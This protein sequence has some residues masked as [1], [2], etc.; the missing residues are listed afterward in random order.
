M[1]AAS[2]GL[3]LA[4]LAVTVGAVEPKNLVVNGDF[5]RLNAKGQPV[6]WEMAGENTWVQTEA[7]NHYLTVS[8]RSD[9]FVPWASQ[10]IDLPANTRRISI[11]ARMKAEDFEPGD[12]SWQTIR[13]G[14]EFR[15][16][17]GERTGYLPPLNLNESTD[18]WVNLSG[19]GE[20]PEGTVRI[21]LQ[22]AQ[23]GKQ[24]VASFDDI[25]IAVSESVPPQPTEDAAQPKELAEQWRSVSAEAVSPTRGRLVVDGW[26]KFMPATPETQTEPDDGGW[27]YIRVPGHWASSRTVLREGRGPAWRQWQADGPR[28]V[29]AAWYQREVPIPADW[30][31]RAILLEIGRV[32]TDAVVYVNGKSCGQINWPWGRV[33]ITDAVTPGQPAKVSLF[34]AATL[35][36]KTLQRMMGDAPGQAFKEK[37]KLRTRGITEPVV[38]HSRPRGP[39]V[40]DVFVQP[41]V[42]KQ[43]IT[44]DLELTGV[45]EAGP[46]KLVAKMLDEQ[47]EAEQTFERTIEA[48]AKDVQRVSLTW[49]WEDARLWDEGQPN[50]Y[51]LRLHTQ[52]QGVDDVYATRFGFREFWIEGRNYYL[53]GRKFRARTAQTGIDRGQPI[54]EQIERSRSIGMNLLESW[55][56][57]L[58]SERGRDHRDAEWFAACDEAGMPI[59]GVMPHVGWKGSKANTDEEKADLERWT[60]RVRRRYGNHPSIVMWGSSGNA[61]GAE[62]DPR[63]VGNYEQSRTQRMR[64]V[65]RDADAQ[66]RLEW[67]EK[68][69][70]RIDPTRP[71]FFHNCGHVGDV[72]TLNHYLNMTPLQERMEWISQY[73]AD[74]DMPLWY[75][76]FGMP[77]HGSVMRGRHGWGNTMQTEPL[78]TE[79]AAIYQ[80]EQAYADEPDDYRQ[81]IAERHIEDQAYQT[82]HGNKD[83]M[84][85]RPFQL[86]AGQFTTETFRAWRTLGMTGGMIPWTDD[87]WF[88]DGSWTPTGQAM[89]DSNMPT[90]AWICGSEQAGVTD[91]THHFRSGDSV[92]KRIAILNDS[93]TSRRV[94]LSWSARSGD[95]EL[96]SGR[97]EM[98]IAPGQTR[99]ATIAFE[100]PDVKD[101]GKQSGELSIKGT[102]GDA[103]H[104]DSFAFTTFGTA[105]RV[106]LRV[107]AADSAGM[108]STMLQAAG[109]SVEPWDGQPTDRLVIVGRQHDQIESAKFW[110]QIRRH[111]E[112][113]GRC[114]VFVQRPE[115]WR[116]VFDFR[117]AAHQSR[118]VFTIDGDHPIATGLDLDD[119]RHWTG[120]ST[121]LEPHPTYESDEMSPYNVPYHGWRWGNRH[122]VSSGA[123]EK[124]HRAGWR[125][126]LQCEFD[127]AYSPLMELDFGKGRLT[128]CQLDLEDHYEQ[129][130]AAERMAVRVIRHAATADLRARV[131]TYFV[132][133]DEGKARL[134]ALDLRYQRTDRLP[135]IEETAL[136][137]VEDRSS[138]DDGELSRWVER[139][140]RL[141]VLAGDQ[142]GGLL[143]IQRKRVDDYGGIDSLTRSHPVLAGLGAS[144]LRYRVDHEAWL[145]DGGVDERFAD[146]QLGVRRIGSGIAVFAQLNPGRFDA[147]RQTY[148]RFTRWR[149]TRAL[150]QVLANLGAR[151]EQDDRV[152]APDRPDPERQPI[153]VALHG[154]WQVTVTQPMPAAPSPA[155]AHRDPGMSDTARQIVESSD[156]HVDWKTLTA[157]G[158]IEQIDGWAAVD[159]E[160][161]L[162]RTFEAPD[163]LAGK[164]CWLSLGVVDDFDSTFINGERVGQVDTRGWEVERMYRVPP[165]LLKPGRNT[166]VV[167]G[168]DHFGGGGL[169]GERDK[170]WIGEKP[171]EQTPRLSPLYHPDYRTDF[172]LGDDPYRYYNF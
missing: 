15:D 124:P 44:L 33:D 114:L 2:A 171:V 97:V 60:D 37:A 51:E 152:F 82:F 43:Q 164:A 168:W 99:F 58:W 18:D 79:Y 75:V 64:T 10:S 65:P 172:D 27:G 3:V 42:R 76:E 122:T 50:L 100:A 16:A 6:C 162:R 45:S 21:Q 31:G 143:G 103:E 55:P 1:S 165:G 78:V 113:G 77:V 166:I 81:E 5:E 35:H 126:I 101:G 72:Y 47:G 49:P 12:K 131:D 69:I 142:P 130:P 156:Q 20:V 154:D 70:K 110:G 71:V 98:E 67:M 115:V 102:V 54:P 41:S 28:S 167:R 29:S 153:Q 36:Q 106:D 169:T 140:N 25:V 107:A 9:S 136:L 158:Q 19:G 11:R 90:L 137:I 59:T 125:P 80:G 74:G 96:K 46:V 56:M 94:D 150:T 22:A 8:K 123:L 87:F 39:H 57:D 170:L 62:K 135:A 52:G 91:R 145:I 111:V 127:L 4:A 147:D 149:Q 159:G 61:M 92:A 66:E 157:P 30:D 148:F 138:L 116:K 160:Y 32:S 119:L 139:G 26:W 144:D 38:L 53:N 163:G 40:S 146:G 84:L 7:D 161:V 73:A 24:G 118:R 128:L 13:L 109:A 129:D 93:A 89:R 121:L 14:G 17:K 83:V 117:V 68:T 85:S 105:A 88:P 132:G 141:L 134:D 155:N 23:F 112:Q 120:N 86:I 108:T 104:A 151:F 63:V 48:E 34:V 95:E 133:S